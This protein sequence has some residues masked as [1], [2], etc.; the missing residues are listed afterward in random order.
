MFDANDINFRNAPHID[1]MDASCNIA[2]WEIRKALMDN[3]N[4]VNIIFLHAFDRMGI[5]P[6]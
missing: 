3:D 4:Q 1:A 5:N 2:G 6:K